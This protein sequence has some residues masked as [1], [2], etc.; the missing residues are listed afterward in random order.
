MHTVR[1]G[2]FALSNVIQRGEGELRHSSHHNFQQNFQLQGYCWL[3][4]WCSRAG[5]AK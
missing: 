3:I 2:L 1:H 4:S 5:A